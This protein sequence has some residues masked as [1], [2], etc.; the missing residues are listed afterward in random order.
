G[1]YPLAEHWNGSAWMVQPTPAPAGSVD[2]GFIGVSCPGLD[3]CVAV[4]DYRLSNGTVLPLAEAWHASSGWTIQS[5][6]EPGGQIGAGLD[7]VTCASNTPC[8]AV[9]FQYGNSDQLTLAEIWNGTA[10]S[11][12]STPNRTNS[13]SLAAVSCTSADAC[14]AVGST[15]D[16]TST[17]RTLAEFWNGTS[18]VIQPTPS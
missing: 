8:T 7:G 6:P 10:W 18:W 1:P 13:A 17:S 3:H 14:I 5:A 12:E 9:G 4:G 15:G 11:I 16:T 2:A